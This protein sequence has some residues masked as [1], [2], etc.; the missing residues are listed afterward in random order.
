[1]C[2]LQDA[3]A[4]FLLQYRG[5]AQLEGAFGPQLRETLMCPAGGSGP[6]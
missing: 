3:G 1:M 5:P 2:P 4:I 6:A